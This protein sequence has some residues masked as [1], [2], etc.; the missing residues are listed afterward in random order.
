MLGTMVNKIT[1]LLL[2]L[3][4]NYTIK[5]FIFKFRMIRQNNYKTRQV[6][7]DKLDDVLDDLNEVLVA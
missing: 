7:G 5:K 1:R 3:H 2:K 6:F 4:D